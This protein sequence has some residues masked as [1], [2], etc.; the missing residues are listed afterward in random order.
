MKLTKDELRVMLDV[1]LR[2]HDGE[3]GCDDALAG[4]PALA[5]AELARRPPDDSPSS[6]ARE[7][8]RAHLAL[9]PECSEEYRSLLLA[10]ADRIDE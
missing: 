1:L 6:Q 8:V 9:C 3:I 5:E 7:R 10:I 4:F 2:T